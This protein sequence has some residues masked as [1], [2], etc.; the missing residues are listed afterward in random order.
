MDNTTQLK[1]VIANVFMS[2]GRIVSFQ[3]YN[4]KA[5]HI[6]MIFLYWIC[7]CKIIS[8]FGLVRPTLISFRCVRRHVRGLDLL[9]RW[10]LSLYEY[11]DILSV[12][13]SGSDNLCC[14]SALKLSISTIM[15]SISNCICKLVCSGYV[16]L[17]PTYVASSDGFRPLGAPCNHICL[18]ELPY[19]LH[20]GVLMIRTTCHFLL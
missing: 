4:V 20:W 18:H 10:N 8:D 11:N 6:Y 17:S 14:W 15:S 13:M 2:P 1:Y 7:C 9:L 12:L 3:V 19:H 16:T 5:G